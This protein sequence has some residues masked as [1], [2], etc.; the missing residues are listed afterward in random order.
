[1]GY[2]RRV[3]TLEAIADLLE[4]ATRASVTQYKHANPNALAYKIREAFTLTKLYPTKYPALTEL[5]KSARV[6]INSREGT[7]TV[8]ARGAHNGSRVLADTAA[9]ASRPSALENTIEASPTLAPSAANPE[10]RVG[11]AISVSRLPDE[12]PLAF[13]QMSRFEIVTKWEELQSN[14]ATM[15]RKF[16]VEAVGLS[17]PDLDKLARWAALHRWLVI[18][19]PESDRVTFLPDD[20][21]LRGIA[22]TPAA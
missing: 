12:K 22:W 10:S 17:A 11:A 18:A 14:G 15:N 21:N 13:G 20:P 2:S 19:D 9:I 8:Y 6:S 4:P 3:K 7:V 1:M 5:A 16:S